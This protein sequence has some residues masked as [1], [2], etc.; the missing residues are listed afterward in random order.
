MG[1]QGRLD[2]KVTVITGAAN[3]H[4]RAT[5]LLFSTEGAKQVLADI[6]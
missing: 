6:K 1:K 3:G 4:G 5:A 2:G